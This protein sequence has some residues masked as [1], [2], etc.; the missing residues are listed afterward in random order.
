M[1]GCVNCLDELVCACV[2]IGT[3]VCWA[4]ML[5]CVAVGVLAVLP[6]WEHRCGHCGRVCASHICAVCMVCYVEYFTAC[7]CVYVVLCVLFMFACACAARLRA[8]VCAYVRACDANGTMTV[9]YPC[10]SAFIT[11]RDDEIFGLTF[12]DHSDVAA[13]ASLMCCASV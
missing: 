2:S 4:C 1:R 5:V 10:K 9:C 8:H 3:F 13:F 11:R 7:A 6:R 12:M